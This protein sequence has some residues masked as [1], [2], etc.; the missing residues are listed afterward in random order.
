[1]LL[2]DSL[3]ELMDI[4]HNDG[5]IFLLNTNGYFLTHDKAIRLSKYK[6]HWI[7]VSIDGASE[8]YHDEFRRLTGSWRHAIKA[9]QMVAE[10]GIPL[11]IAHCVTPH[12]LYDINKICD[13]A[14]GIGATSIMIGGVSF[15]GRAAINKDILLDK[16]QQKVLE[17]EIRE[18]IA[19]YAGKMYVRFTNSVYNGLKRHMHKPTEIA[20]IRPNGDIRIDGM[21]P[22]VV[23]NILKDDFETVWIN[24]LESG[25]HDSRVLSYINGYNEND[26]NEELVN[27][28][29]SDVYLY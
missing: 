17:E 29:D 15:S 26:R 27:Y 3:L 23:G 16:T 25:W 13:L 8:Q 10:Y 1:M 11:K 24:Q 19:K 18:N 20:V 9:A 21:A 6:Y 4:F 14:Y 28:I 5:S 12:N 7:Q 2:G 22:F